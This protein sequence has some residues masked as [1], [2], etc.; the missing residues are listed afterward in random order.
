MQKRKTNAIDEINQN[1]KVAQSVINLA[2]AKETTSED[3]I[4]NIN[5]RR[6]ILR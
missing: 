5:R 4:E 6:I 3:E 1:F 2:R